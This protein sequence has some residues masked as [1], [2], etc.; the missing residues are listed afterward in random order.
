L[1]KAMLERGGYNDQEIQAYFTRP[2][3]SINH[4]RVLEIRKGNKHKAAKAASQAELDEFL[5]AWPELDP[6]TGL[7]L[8]GDDC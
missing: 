7:S 1:V 4:A 8:G 2:S 3:R 6:E 5:A